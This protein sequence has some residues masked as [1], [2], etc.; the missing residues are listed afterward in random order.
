MMYLDE[1]NDLDK[2]SVLAENKEFNIHIFMNN[3]IFQLYISDYISFLEYSERM[4]L[5]DILGIDKLL[6]NSLLW[7]AD[8]QK[9]NKGNYYIALK[10]SKVYNVLINEEIV[11]ISELNNENNCKIEKIIKAELETGEYMYTKFNHNEFGSTFL[12]KHFSS[13]DTDIFENIVDSEVSEIIS[14][15]ESI[16]NLDLVNISKDNVKVKRLCDEK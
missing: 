2:I 12:E 1:Q 9:V 4:K 16:M 5:I 13:N 6:S 15:T 8:L 3:N 7:N 11:M 10:N 14:D